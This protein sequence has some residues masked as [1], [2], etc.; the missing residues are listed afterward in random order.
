MSGQ[1]F[2]G[3][4]GDNKEI[5]L[6]NQIPN[7]DQTQPYITPLDIN[8]PLPN[9]ITPY[10]CTNI[11]NKPINPVSQQD[12]LPLN[13]DS[14]QT[15]MNKNTPHTP[16]QY[17]NNKNIPEIP[18]KYIQQ[19]DSNTFYISYYSDKCSKVFP[20]YIIL[21][22]LAV[23]ALYIILSIYELESFLGPQ[24]IILFAGIILDLI[25]IIFL[26]TE[27]HSIYIILGPNSLN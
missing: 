3:S 9:N 10:N 23:A 26:F 1:P 24:L 25:G 14:P 16:S 27:Y 17:Q 2:I 12:G 22:G 13:N 15:Q 18:F 19:T 20:L 5:L 4:D 8:H 21:G 11:E 7:Q 6:D